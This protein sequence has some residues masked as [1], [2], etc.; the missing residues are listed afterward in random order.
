MEQL[1]R[2]PIAPETM[3]RLEKVEVFRLRFR[4]LFPTRN[5]WRSFQRSR[6][7]EL[8]QRALLFELTA[9][10]YVDGDKLAN[11]LGDLMTV[12]R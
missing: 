6:Q 5:A 2:Q 12:N 7:D 9:G 8:M 10:W 4:N 3:A 11:A 1:I